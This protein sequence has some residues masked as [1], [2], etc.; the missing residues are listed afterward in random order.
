MKN[1]IFYSIFIILYF[2]AQ[3]QINK[4]A[5]AAFKKFDNALSQITKVSYDI[6]TY[7]HNPANNYF[8]TGNFQTYAE[9]DPKKSA[10]L[11]KIM[12]NSKNTSRIFNNSELFN[13][14]HVQKTYELENT[15]ATTK[16]LSSSS[17]LNNSIISLKVALPEI[18]KDE[19]IIKTV[20]D[21]VID[22]KKYKKLGFS[23][24]GK[25]LDFPK[26]FYVFNNSEVVQYFT[27]IADAKTYLPYRV[28]QSNSSTKDYYYQVTMENINTKPAPPLPT[29]WFYSGYPEYTQAVKKEQVELVKV[30]Q[31]IP[32]WK[33]PLYTTGTAPDSLHSDALKGKLTVIEFWI[34]NCGYCMD[35]FK[36]LKKLQEKYNG[37]NVQLVSIN[38]YDTKEDVGFF[39]KREKAAY[40]MLYD[41]T[42]LAEL[43]GVYAYPKTIILNEKNEVIYTESGFNG[44][45][46]STFIDNYNKK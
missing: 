26:P 17:G 14:N 21:T 8:Y 30:G 28:I 10:D 1:L 24:L 39:H 41:G 20:S 36:D 18:I 23:L 13:L 15:R 35:A 43:L 11:Q 9:F 45:K 3:S 2:P 44:E 25:T 5:L 19:S 38:A 22:H 6:E 29:D 34:K 7:V 16:H 27:I 40:A 46:V 37:S 42:L 32:E 31:T 33:L 12:L 4:E